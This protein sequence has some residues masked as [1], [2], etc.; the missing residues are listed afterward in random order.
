MLTTTFYPTLISTSL[1]LQLSVYPTVHMTLSHSLPCNHPS[2]GYPTD[3]LYPLP[4]AS[5]LPHS[6][7]YTGLLKMIVGVLKTC[8]T[9]HLR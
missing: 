5:D 6:E 7:T 1:S 8:H 4:D 9:I 2:L 3:L